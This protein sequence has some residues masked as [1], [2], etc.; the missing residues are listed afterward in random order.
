MELI[1]THTNADFDALASM[2][3]AKMLYPRAVLA[4]AGA[5]EKNPL[6]FFSQSLEHVY[7]FQR[8]KNKAFPPL[9]FTRKNEHRYQHL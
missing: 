1:T 4:F 7:D 3:A 5:Q 9:F 8:L 6:D 2:V